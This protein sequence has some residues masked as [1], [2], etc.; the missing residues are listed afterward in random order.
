MSVGAFGHLPS[1]PY[2][3]RNHCS[4]L[5]SP[6]NH[7]FRGPRH[8]R[9]CIWSNG[10]ACHPS[11]RQDFRSAHQ[12]GNN[13]RP[14]DRWKNDPGNV[15]PVHFV[16]TSRRTARGLHS[17]THFQSIRIL[18]RPRCYETG[19]RSE[20]SY[21]DVAG[22]FRDLRAGN[23]RIPSLI[24]SSQEARRSCAHRID[25]VRHYSRAGS[26]DQRIA[27]SCQESGTRAC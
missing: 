13:A 1:C 25:L 9:I 18:S 5:S 16:P 6:R 4:C 17:Q 27:E 7:S 10:C 22:N 3:T 12:P 8:H 2:R 11:L 19:Y 14:H 20:P 23:V 26:V 24:T 21:W 15:C